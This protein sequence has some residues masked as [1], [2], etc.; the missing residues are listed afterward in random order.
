MLHFNF[1]DSPP[2]AARSPFGSS[3]INAGGSLLGGLFSSSGSHYAARKQLQAVRETNSMNYQI[4]QANNAFNEK[5]WNAQNEYNTPISQ[6]QRLEQA[7]LNPYLMLDGSST[8]NAQSSVTADQSGT[9]VAPE[10]GQTLASGY[11]QLGLSIS[12]AAGRIAQMVYNNDLQQANVQKTLADAK[13]SDLQNQY[14][15]LRNSFAAAQFLAELRLKQYQGKISRYEANY[16]RDSM[17]DRL[18]S[19]NFDWQLKGHQSSYYDQLAGLTD[20]QR[21]IQNINLSWLPREKSA[22]LAATLQNVRTMVSE[23]NLNYAQAKNAFAMAVLNYAQSAGVRIDNR[24][25]DSTFDLSVKLAKNTVNTEYWNQKNAKLNYHIG[26]QGYNDSQKGLNPFWRW[27]NCVFPC[28]PIDWTNCS[29]F[30]TKLNCFNYSNS[31]FC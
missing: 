21:Q 3:L 17:K 25:K 22:D 14:D 10:F 6:R 2:S 12:D 15:S 8:G 16:L 31:F 13:N 7:G 26:N 23:M 19:A 4:A 9:Q 27:F 30:I 20:I 28:F 1:L 24:L 18:Q 5:M 11:Q 29:M